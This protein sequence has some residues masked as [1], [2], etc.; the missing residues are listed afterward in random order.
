MDLKDVIIGGKTIQV[1]PLIADRLHAANQE[2]K[3]KTG[4]EFQIASAYRT[5]AQQSA[6]YDKLAPTGAQVAPPG[7]SF[8]EAGDAVDVTNWQ[9][10]QPYLNK[11]QLRNDLSNDKNHFSVGET[12]KMPFANMTDQV[13]KA[14]QKGLSDT[15]IL[16][17][18]AKKLPNFE[19]AISTARAKGTNDSNIIN[20]IALI[21]GGSIPNIPSNPVP[22]DYKSPPSSDAKD[23]QRVAAAKAAGQD[24]VPGQG[25]QPTKQPGFWGKL[26]QFGSAMIENAGKA[27]NFLLEQTGLD[28]GVG[29]VKAG[30]QGMGQVIGGIEGA[31]GETAKQTAG[32]LKGQGFHPGEILKTAQDIA[33]KTGEFGGQSGEAGAKAG[34]LG[35]ATG[36]VGEVAPIAETGINAVTMTSQGIEAYKQLKQGIT[37]NDPEAIAQGLGALGFTAMGAKGLYDNFTSTGSFDIAN[38]KLPDKVKSYLEAIQENSPEK[39]KPVI[40]AIKKLSEKSLTKPPATAEELT[41]KI[42]QGKTT[43]IKAGKSGLGQIDTSKVKTYE[44]LTKTANQYVKDTAQALDEKLEKNTAKVRLSKF[45][46]LINTGDRVI[47]ANPVKDMI[48]QLKDH[49]IATKEYDNLEKIIQFED[50]ADSEG[51][52]VKELNDLA[53]EHGQA[54]NAFNANGQA[55]SGLSKQAAEN[56]RSAVKDVAREEYGGKEYKAMDKQMSDAIKVRDLA[57]KMQEKVN[58]LKQKVKERSWGAKVGILLGK[59]VNVLGLGT[60]K[61]AVE[62]LTGKANE[63]VRMDAL[64]LEKSLS[65]NLKKLDAALGAKTEQQAVQILESIK[66]EPP[67]PKA[68][69]PATPRMPE[70]SLN[71]KVLSDAEIKAQYPNIGGEKVQEPQKL[72]PE[73]K[74][75]VPQT[76]GKGVINLGKEAPST[77]DA[78]SQAAATKPEGSVSNLKNFVQDLKNDQKGIIGTELTTKPEMSKSVQAFGASGIAIMAG[79]AATGLGA[80]AIGKAAQGQPAQAK[81]PEEAKTP[82]KAKSTINP[83]KVIKA[84][85]YEESRGQSDPYT[86]NQPSGSKKL[87]RALGKYQVTEALLREKSRKYLGETVTP[88]EFMASSTLQEKFMKARVEDWIKR[89]FTLRQIFAAHRGGEGNLNGHQDYVDEAVGQYNK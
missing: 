36:G 62:F 66:P 60:P 14:R 32:A 65:K 39:L 5:D 34:L 61:G 89:G 73:G 31:V 13:T 25:L 26:G 29:M 86:F 47:N 50:K 78:K 85:S 6:L 55:A 7:Q 68:L 72:L 40:E 83:D 44:D 9:E 30:A 74:T 2:F 23:Q 81:K 52:T 82:E 87:G 12:A 28:A 63:P 58:T 46:K 51:V 17:N 79:T 71:N 76:T 21:Y 10:A 64:D 11:Y 43:D 42:L 35:I 27:G 48:Q 20:K 8:H 1:S 33:T 4:K 53:R 75:T 84:L 67:T 49:Y 16:D 59:A 18:L 22:K 69:P 3:A 77:V 80:L 38:A 37:N 41:G 70:S 24:Y 57:E 45:D 19:K 56:T 88:D 54:I 15:Q